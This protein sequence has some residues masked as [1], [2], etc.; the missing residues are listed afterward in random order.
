MEKL[1]KSI[2]VT[3]DFSNVS[4]SALKHAFLLSTNVE[5]SIV[6]FHIVNED[7][8]KAA[9]EEKLKLKA[10]EIKKE[11]PDILLLQE[12]KEGRIQILVEK[13]KTLY[14]DGEPHLAYA[15]QI[16]QA[17]ISRYPLT[18][19]QASPHKGRAQEVR[20]ETPFG[21]ITVINIHAYK[22]RWLRRHQQMTALLGKDVATAKNP[23]ILGGD[24][25]TSDQSQTYRLVDRYLKNAHW[26]AGCGYSVDQGSRA[27]LANWTKRSIFTTIRD[28]VSI[29]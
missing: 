22:F 15:P 11:H 24:F 4:E 8:E 17:V 23:V 9:A 2:L 21:P 5:Y 28:I 12:I 1:K 20:L 10:E 26:E 13:L 19:L 7:S 25:N 18:P 16:L 29:A 3:W 14:S 27:I 6:L